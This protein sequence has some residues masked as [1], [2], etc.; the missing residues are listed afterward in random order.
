MMIKKTVVNIENKVEN[1]VPP[2]MVYD[3][4]QKMK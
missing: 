1:E 3:V 2:N 4:V